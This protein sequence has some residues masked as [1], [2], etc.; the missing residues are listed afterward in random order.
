MIIKVKKLGPIKNVSLNLSKDLIIFSGE[1]NSGKSLLSYLVYGI[2]DTKFDLENLSFPGID[3]AYSGN[4]EYGEIDLN[5][6]FVLN[7]HRIKEKIVVNLVR[8]LSIIYGTNKSIYKD[9]EIEV[10][11]SLI[12][13][14]KRLEEASFIEYFEG[15]DEDDNSLDISVETILG[16]TLLTYGIEDERIPREDYTYLIEHSCAD[17]LLQFILPNAIF[18]PAERQGVLVFGKELIVNRSK[19]FEQIMNLEKGG[20]LKL[21]KKISENEYSYSQPITDNLRLIQEIITGPKKRSNLADVAAKIESNILDGEIIRTD[22]GN[23]RFTPAGTDFSLDISF[24]SSTVKSLSLLIYYLKYK[25]KKGDLIIIDEPELN[26]HPNNQIELLRFL[27]QLVNLG[28]KLLISTHSDYF[29]R[30]LN[31]L[32]TL[33]SVS[34]EKKTQRDNLLEKYNLNIH[35]IINSDRLGAFLF[36]EKEIENLQVSKDGFE[37][38]TIDFIA[39]QQNDRVSNIHLELI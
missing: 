39:D 21:M 8:R 34:V 37:I 23:L 30:E 29:I 4:T 36:K 26:L 28:F 27:V 31:S 35:M 15:I 2:H 19:S 11:F 13:V 18:F 20:K 22:G 25:A 33:G 10:E 16:K 9:S 24:S 14:K 7:Q 1:N 6:L 3:F 17:F 38:E 5:D 32:I 12:D